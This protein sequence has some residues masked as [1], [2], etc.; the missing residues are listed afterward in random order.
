ML[1]SAVRIGANEAMA[2]P[3]GR[4][5]VRMDY[6]KGCRA[7]AG[8]GRPFRQDKIALRRCGNRAVKPRLHFILSS[9]PKRRITLIK[10]LSC[11]LSALL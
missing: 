6:A 11:D 5:V 7:V 2:T 10:S 9:T 4:A 3:R 1:R 8:F